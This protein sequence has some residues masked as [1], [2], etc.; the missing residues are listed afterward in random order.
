MEREVSISSFGRASG[1]DE[2]LSSR[3][4]RS[5][6]TL[7]SLDSR[8]AAAAT[9]TTTTNTRGARRHLWVLICAVAMLTIEIG[10]PLWFNKNNNNHRYHH[11]ARRPTFRASRLLQRQGD[12]PINEGGGGPPNRNGSNEGYAGTGFASEPPKGDTGCGSINQYPPGMRPECHDGDGVDDTIPLPAINGTEESDPVLPSFMPPKPEGVVP[13]NIVNLTVF[14]ALPPQTPSVAFDVTRLLTDTMNASIDNMNFFIRPPPPF[15]AR[16]EEESERF[17]SEAQESTENGFR[18][19]QTMEDV[20]PLLNETDEGDAPP[21]KNRTD[22]FNMIYTRT[23]SRVVVHDDDLWWWQYDLNYLCF[24]EE[25]GDKVKEGKMREIWGIMWETVFENLDKLESLLVNE[26]DGEVLA[27]ELNWDN[28]TR[29]NTKEPTTPV[30][31]TFPEKLN[32]R[33]WSWSRYLG[34]CVFVTV[35]SGL[36]IASYIGAVRRRQRIRKQVWGNLASEEGVKELLNTGWV[37]HKDRMEV[38]DKTRVGYRDDDS[39]LIGGFEQR[40]P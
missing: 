25:D 4:Q 24:W 15:N 19:L 1:A 26:T 22:R 40:E 33:E 34:F 35:V 28:A 8:V 31:E 37:L 21:Q 32:A 9:T 29:D 23:K 36:I 17:P 11:G 27:L 38:Y 10:L 14:V 2:F 12:N 20:D 16:D 5:R 39:M 6:A 3:Q 30:F 13:E 18:L 7:D